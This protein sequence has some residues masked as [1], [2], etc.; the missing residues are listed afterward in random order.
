MKNFY[1][2]K[3]KKKNSYREKKKKKNG[4]FPWKE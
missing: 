2:G 1:K 4:N 3:C